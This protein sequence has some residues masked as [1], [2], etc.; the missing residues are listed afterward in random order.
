MAFAMQS[1][2][3]NLLLQTSSAKYDQQGCLEPPE[4][5]LRNTFFVSSEVDRCPTSR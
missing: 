1:S 4:W 2:T 5:A 3:S